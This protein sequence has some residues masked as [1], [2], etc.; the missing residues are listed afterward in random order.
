MNE[1]VIEVDTLSQGYGRH[2][3]LDQIDLRAGPGEVIGLIGRNGCGKTTLLETL[4]GLQQPS[5]GQCRLLGQFSHEMPEEVRQQFGFV[6]QE[7]ELFDWMMVS[8][9]VDL[10]GSMY[11][12][13]DTSRVRQLLERWRVP[14][15][16]R[17]N[18]LSRGQRQ[19][20]GIIL[21]LG[22]SPRVLLLDE[23]ASALDPVARREFL[24]ELVELA[25]DARRT[26]VFSSH[27]LADVERVATRIWLMRGGRVLLD[28]S[29]DRLKEG[30]VQLRL[31]NG[32]KAAQLPPQ[33]SGELKRQ[34]HD[35][36]KSVLLYEPA[37][38]ELDGLHQ[39][40]GD[41]LVTRSMG[42]DELAVELLS[43]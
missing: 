22:H 10:V 27:L 6:F 16:E 41:Q 13:W 26:I 8:D 32:R 21:A 2:E 19:M 31:H 30:M 17:V 42:L 14:A 36:G 33:L 40:L 18:R 34:Q 12:N 23:P 5:N 43:E 20:L 7:E 3:V 29:L 35:W 39:D 28:D 37:R 1:F 15:G 25:L 38:E 11:A 24:G 9:H 4:A